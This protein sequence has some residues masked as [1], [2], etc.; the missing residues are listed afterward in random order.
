M[1][2]A[3]RCRR[4]LAATPFAS[5]AGARRA[6][7]TQ[8]RAAT[9][10]AAP[11]SAAA[12]PPPPPGF[13]L[14]EEALLA[15]STFPIAPAAL[16]E[17]C[18]ACLLTNFGSAVP[19]LLAEDFAFVAPV[20]GPLKKEAF[21]SA[22]QS[23]DVLTAFPDMRFQYHHFRV[24]PL[25]PCRVWFTSRAVST[26]TGSFANAIPATGKVVESP[27]QGCSMRFNEAGECT[28]LTVGY[29]LDRQLGNT[30]GLGA[31]FGLLYAIGAPLPFREAQPW[32]ASLR[33]KAFLKLPAVLAALKKFTPGGG[34]K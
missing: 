3:A 10:D 20:V 31:V 1:Q 21:V 26:H 9:V 22:F 29:V 27:P 15:E 34:K 14:D 24:D 23:F 13:F 4:A 8:L 25:E 33:Y 5:A 30:G 7:R 28:Q 32:K 18:K 17:K 16:I 6:L 19:E 12:V 11:S 2:P